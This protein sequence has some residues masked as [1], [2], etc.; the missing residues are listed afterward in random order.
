MSDLAKIRIH[1]FEGCTPNNCS[2]VYFYYVVQR[3]AP[4]AAV[5]AT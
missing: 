1:P 5:S 4:A 2:R 3:Q